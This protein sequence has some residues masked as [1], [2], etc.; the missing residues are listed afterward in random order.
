MQIKICSTSNCPVLC[1]TLNQNYVNVS[2]EYNFSYAVSYCS[3][4]P[5]NSFHLQFQQDTERKRKNRNLTENDCG[6]YS[7]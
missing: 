7:H 3:E 5:S 1:I 6:S 4:K 2:S